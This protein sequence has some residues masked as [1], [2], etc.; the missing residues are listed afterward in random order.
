MAKQVR[1]WQVKPISHRELRAR[2]AVKVLASK[3]HQG[4]GVITSI[5]S[6]DLWLQSNPVKHHKI[7]AW[8]T[9][10]DHLCVKSRNL[11]SR[12]LIAVIKLSI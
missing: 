2:Q 4:Q 9:G 10:G 8:Q 6:P 11:D 12:W 7:I 3:F 5:K 1:P